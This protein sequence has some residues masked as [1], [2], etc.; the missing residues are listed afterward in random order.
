MGPKYVLYASWTFWVLE[1]LNSSWT[2]RLSRVLKAFGVGVLGLSP[3]TLR[4]SFDLKEMAALK[5]PF[6]GTLESFWAQNWLSVH[7]AV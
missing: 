3:K 4:E 5:R 1:H 2:H 6:V 7:T